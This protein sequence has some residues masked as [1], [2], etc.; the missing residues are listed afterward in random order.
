MKNYHNK[1]FEFR[2]GDR[3]NHV[4]DEGAIETGTI[5]A[6]LEPNILEIMFDDGDEGYETTITCFK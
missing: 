6:I 4:N 1:V 5:R 2:I 3:V